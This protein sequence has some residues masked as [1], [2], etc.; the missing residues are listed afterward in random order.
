MTG[1]LLLSISVFIFTFFISLICLVPC[2]RLSWLFGSFWAHVNILHRIVS[3]CIVSWTRLRSE[4]DNGCVPAELLEAQYGEE[5]LSFDETGSATERKAG[6]GRPKSA[7]WGTNIARVEELIC[8]QE[9]QSGQHLSTHE[10][11][12][13][14]D[15]SDRSVRRIAKKDLYCLN[16]A[17]LLYV[18]SNVFEYVIIAR[19]HYCNANNFKTLFDN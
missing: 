2:G 9:G 17:T 7:R 4:G 8:S 12:A 1:P 3:Y 15:T 11:A 19:W 16:N 18:C 13:K 10:I 14:L 5:N 6:S